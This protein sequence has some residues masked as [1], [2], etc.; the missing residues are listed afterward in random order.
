MAIPLISIAIIVLASS[1]I[2]FIN[3]LKSSGRT[4]AEFERLVHISKQYV[5]QGDRDRQLLRQS[6]A[7]LKQHEETIMKLKQK[8]QQKKIQ[9][10]A[11]PKST[12]NICPIDCILPEVN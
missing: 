7:R 4:E 5:E 9:I 6:L 10:D 2:Y 1:G 3:T 8:T 11:L 12:S